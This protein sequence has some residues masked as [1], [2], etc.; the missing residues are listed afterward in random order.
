MFTAAF[1]VDDG[2][3]TKLSM[4]YTLAKLIAGVVLRHWRAHSL[5]A[6]RATD[7]RA[8]TNLFDTGFR[9]LADKARRAMV[10]LFALQATGFGVGQR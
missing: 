1:Q 4:A 3:F 6:D 8:Q 7:R 10:N 2:A 9:Q 5:M